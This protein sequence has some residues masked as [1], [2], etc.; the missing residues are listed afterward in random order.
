[1]SGLVLLAAS[2]FV[3][4]FAPDAVAARRPPPPLPRPLP[5][6]LP[7]DPR[8]LDWPLWNRSTDGSGFTSQ[9]DCVVYTRQHNTLSQLQFTALPNAELTIY[10]DATATGA[11][12]LPG[13]SV[14]ITWVSNYDLSGDTERTGTVASDGTGS[15]TGTFRCSN[16]PELPNLWVKFVATATTSGGATL[17]K[18]ITSFPC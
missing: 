6:P 16:T 11:G 2:A 14:R 8:C 12:L 5:V 13:S 15:A 9:L 4:V 18:E 1:M 10:F 17:T 7:G 3:G